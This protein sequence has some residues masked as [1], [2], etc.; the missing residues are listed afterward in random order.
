MDPAERKRSG[1]KGANMLIQQS[2]DEDFYSAQ[3]SPEAYKIQG[4]I[5]KDNNVPVSLLPKYK[6]NRLA[7]APLNVDRM[8]IS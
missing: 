4:Y 1:H 3:D 2:L 8:R 5:M 7:H 6:I